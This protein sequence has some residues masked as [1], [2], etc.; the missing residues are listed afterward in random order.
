MRFLRLAQLVAELRRELQ[1]AGPAAH[2]DDA[3]QP[4]LLRQGGFILAGFAAEPVGQEGRVGRASRAG[5][6]ALRRRFRLRAR[7]GIAVER[8]VVGQFPIAGR[9]VAGTC[10]GAV[11]YREHVGR[12]A[13]PLGSNVQEDLADFRSF[14]AY[15]AAR[16]LHRKTA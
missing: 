10:N 5:E 8:D 3:V 2:H 14:K 15:R 11:L 4:G 1:T 13:E 6:G 12:N 9:D 16:M 7:R